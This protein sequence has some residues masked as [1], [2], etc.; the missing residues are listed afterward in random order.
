MSDFNVLY[1][2][3]VV[4]SVINIALLIFVYTYL[5]NLEAKGC[6]CAYTPNAGFIKGFT[7]FAIFYLLIT[8]FVP[9]EMIKD[10][11]GGSL[12][13]FIGF[14]NII[15]Y[16]VFAYYLYIVFQYTRFLVNEKCK[17]S[18]DIRREIIMIGFLIEFALIV[19]LFLFHFLI[20]IVISIIFAVI[21]EL[22]ESSGNIRGVIRD[23]IGSLSKVPATIKKDIGEISSYVSKTRKELSKLGSK[24][25]KTITS[26]LPKSK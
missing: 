14:V 13:V 8:M 20:A 1:I 24:G 9:D 10:N 7:I 4:S 15:F 26:R 11:F 3:R 22:S 16:I 17:C 21:R 25:A 19:I 5:T 2:I 6:E 18:A 23:P 12:L